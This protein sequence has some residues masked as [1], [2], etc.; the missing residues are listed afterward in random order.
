M[1][2]EDQIESLLDLLCSLD[3]NTKVYLGCDS[4]RVKTGDKWYARY[5]T[6]CIVHMNGN[7]GCRVFSHISREP[8][9][10]AKKNR[11]SIRLMH[12]VTKVCQLWEQLKPFI[13]GFDVEI[14]LD[15]NR[16]PK[17]GSNCVATQA[18]GY[19]LGVTGID[20][21]LKPDAWASSIGGDGV[22]HGKQSYKTTIAA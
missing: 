15:L 11:P 8:D 6:V 10:D 2:T 20:P 21:V 18:A 3:A 19:V 4:V 12:E 17:Y 14:H 16:D 5:A 13:D 22:V 1:F 9:Y 7:K